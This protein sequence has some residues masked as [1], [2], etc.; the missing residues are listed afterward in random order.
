MTRRCPVSQE[1]LK[2]GMLDKIENY[3]DIR[4]IISLNTLHCIPKFCNII[5]VCTIFQL[6]CI[7]KL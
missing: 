5:E 1:E 7:I 2:A 4:I 6:P 3:Y